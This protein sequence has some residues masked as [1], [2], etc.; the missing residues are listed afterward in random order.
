MNVSFHISIQFFL[1]FVCECILTRGENKSIFTALGIEANIGKTITKPNEGKTAK[2]KD[3]NDSGC[4]C[5]GDE[6]REKSKFD[7]LDVEQLIDFED[8]LHNTV[9]VK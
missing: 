4:S 6:N 2:D 7:P 3:I 9:Y 8:E 5:D 1:D